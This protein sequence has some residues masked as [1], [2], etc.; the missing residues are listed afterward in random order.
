MSS[1]EF[2]RDRKREQ[3]STRGNWIYITSVQF[4]DEDTSRNKFPSK[5]ESIYCFELNQAEQWE[6]DLDSDLHSPVVKL[7]HL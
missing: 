7:D 6:L 5:V 2:E 4:S 1:F 3:D